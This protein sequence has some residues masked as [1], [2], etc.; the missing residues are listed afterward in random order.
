MPC[1]IADDL[2]EAQIKAYRI[3]DNK[4]NESEWNEDLLR[5]ELEN[6]KELDFNFDDIMTFDFDEAFSQED[7]FEVNLKDEKYSE[8]FSIIIDCE[9][10]LQQEQIYYDCTQKGYKCRVQSL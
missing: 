1:L 8:K 6:L 4:L 10:E 2:N 5:L 3:A 9:S 7:D